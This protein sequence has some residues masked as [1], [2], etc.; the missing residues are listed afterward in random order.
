MYNF[1]TVI[2]S[3]VGN[4]GW[5]CFKGSRESLD[6]KGLFAFDSVGQILDGQGHS[7]LSIATTI[8]GSVI[9]DSRD[10]D[11]YSIMER[12]LGL[13]K[14]VV[15][16]SSK[17][18]TASFVSLAPG[19]L[20]D[21]VF[22]NHDLLDGSARSENF[23]S[24]VVESRDDFSSQDCGESLHTIEVGVLDDHDAGISQELLRVIIDELS[25][26]EYIWLICENL[27][28][29][30]LHLDLLGLLDFSNLHD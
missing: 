28:D 5:K 3:V 1:C 20:D 27:L 30:L 17:D 6:G 9:F 7:H 11:A 18:D 25:V 16:R 24:W 14:D 22:T 8:D 29:L 12:S 15:S 10:Q 21:F 23:G 4:D 13:I 26:N 19:E 2:T